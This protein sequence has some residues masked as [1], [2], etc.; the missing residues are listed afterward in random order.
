[1]AYG[2][3]DLDT[4]APRHDRLVPVAATALGCVVGG[5]E[6]HGG[7]LEEIVVEALAWLHNWPTSLRE[8][9]AQRLSAHPDVET[10]VAMSTDDHVVG[11]CRLRHRRYAGEC[12]LE[13]LY[14]RAPMRGQGIGAAL[15]TEAVVRAGRHGFRLVRAL[16]IRSNL[17]ARRLAARTGFEEL[18]Q[19]PPR[20]A[21]FVLRSINGSQ[22]NA[23]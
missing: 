15:V 4:A 3:R 6:L 16:I 23:G 9:Y 20:D 7:E 19:R 1:M 11:F 22:S 2:I 17:S 21:I 10:I 18:G 5:E 8:A 13:D 12:W 14:V